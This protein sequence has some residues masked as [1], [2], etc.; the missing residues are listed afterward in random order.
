MGEILLVGGSLK[1]NAE[2]KTAFS[3]KLPDYRLLQVAPEKN[4]IL[5]RLSGDTKLA[6]FNYRKSLEETRHL[7]GIRRLGFHEPMLLL[8]KSE[9]TVEDIGI[10]AQKDTVLLHKPYS[11]SD[12]VQLSMKVLSKDAVT[13]RR[14]ARFDFHKPVGVEVFGQSGKIG[15]QM[16]R[17]S[18]GGAF[19]QMIGRG[20]L[21]LGEYI[22]VHV[23]LDD[24]DRYHMVAAQIVNTEAGLGRI[25]GVGETFGIAWLNSP[26]KGKHSNAKPSLLKK[27]G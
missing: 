21:Q 4:S 17:V 7:N 23:Y 10:T 18:Q 19:M 6:I 22:R 24:V 11:E 13:Q 16:L 9:K 1:E 15:A 27:A 12:L 2:I 5:D 3:K 14:H 26:L 20:K 25:V 8:A